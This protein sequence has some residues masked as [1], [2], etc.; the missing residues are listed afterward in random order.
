MMLWE[1][2]ARAGFTPPAEIARRLKRRGMAA[3]PTRQHDDK[4]VRARMKMVEADRASD[5][6][7]RLRQ[8]RD[9]DCEDVPGFLELEDRYHKAIN[10]LVK[11]PARSFEGIAA[12]ARAV[13]HPRL[14]EDYRRHR[15][16]AVSLAQDIL[17]YLGATA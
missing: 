17:K 14:C 10:A 11:T 6:L 15:V 7:L 3:V 13:G 1:M 9:A 5:E 16:V 12:K 4:L 8:N 2:A